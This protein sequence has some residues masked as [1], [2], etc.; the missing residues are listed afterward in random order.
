MP[1][2]TPMASADAAWLHMDSPTKLMVITTALW[3]DEPLG[4][5]D[6]RD[7]LAERLVEPFPR[8]RQRIVEN[9]LP[10]AGPQWEDDPLFDVD[11]HL[12]R[13]GLPA[14][15]GQ[16]ELQELIADLMAVPIDRTKPPWHF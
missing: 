9:R 6:L 3:F 10:L 5:D 16:A 1:A 14:P 7:V 11:L 13:V 8:F 15:G 2:P 12:H 4:Y